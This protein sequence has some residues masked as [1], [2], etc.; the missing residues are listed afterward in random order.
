MPIIKHKDGS[1][2]VDESNST[3][4]DRVFSKNKPVRKTDKKDPQKIPEADK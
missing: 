2:T 4:P 3:D 1:I